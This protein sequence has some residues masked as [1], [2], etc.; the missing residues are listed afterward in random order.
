MACHKGLVYAAHFIFEKCLHF[1]DLG[2]L[3]LHD[4]GDLNLHDLGDLLA[5]R[6]FDYRGRGLSS[7]WRF[8][9]RPAGSIFL[10]AGVFCGCFLVF[11]FF[12][13][14]F[15]LPIKIKCWVG[16]SKVYR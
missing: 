10:V 7:W 1:D 6:S 8:N 11:F 13:V 5:A 14:A 12:F 4:L 16:I 9:H 2:D 3:N 15:F